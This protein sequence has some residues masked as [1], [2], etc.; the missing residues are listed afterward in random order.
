[1]GPRIYF[2]EE[3]TYNPETLFDSDST[4]DLKSSILFDLARKHHLVIVCSEPGYC[5]ASTLRSVGIRAE[6]LGFRFVFRDFGGV[7]PD[8]AYDSIIRAARDAYAKSLNTREPSVVALNLL[9]P[10]DEL[11][12]GRIAHAI[13]RLLK[14]N[15]EVI[16][17]MLP[18]ARQIIEGLPAHLLLTAADLCD[19]SA[20]ARDGSGFVA[21]GEGFTRGIPVLARS[22]LSYKGDFRASSLPQAYWDVLGKLVEA[23]MR[24]S[25]CEDELRL[26]FAIAVLG[27]GSHSELERALGLVDHDLLYDLSLWAPLYGVDVEAGSFSCL[28]AH[29]H[30]WSNGDLPAF[31]ALA[32][33]QQ[34]LLGECLSV[35]GEREDYDRM[36]AMLR[37]ASEATASRIAAEWAPELVDAGYVRQVSA[38]IASAKGMAADNPRLILIDQMVIALT[39][40][41]TGTVADV[42]QLCGRF[43]S[44]DEGASLCLAM[45]GL[46]EQLRTLSGSEV[47]L[48]GSRSGLRT[49]LEVHRG[50]LEA[51]MSGRFG[52]ALELLMPFASNGDI[53][54]VT[55]CLLRADLA[56]AQIFAC[57]ASWNDR[58]D[59]A[60]CK[61]YL[62]SRGYFGL[63]GYV[64]GLE[65]IAEA[66]CT[67]P[68][69]TSGLIRSKAAKSGDL[70]IKALA[71]VSEAFGLL[72]RKP[73][74]YILAAVS[75]ARNACK[76][77]SW[78]YGA[79]VCGVLNQVAHFQLGEC[80]GLYVVG[81]N[82]G[83]GA[84]SEVVGEL[85]HDARTGV[86]PAAAKVRPVPV[87][88]LW[89]IIALCD[90]MGEVSYALEDQ[91][92]V[93]WRRA[94]DVARK[95]SLN[96]TKLLGGIGGSG[97]AARARDMVSRGV[98]ITVF[99]GFSLIADG[100]KVS[101][102]YLGVRDAKP[103]LEFL[104]LQPGHVASREHIALMLWPEVS[105]K[106]KARQKVYSA[107][108]AARKALLKHGFKGDVFSSNKATKSVGLTSDV[109]SCDVDD[110]ICHAN[111]AIDG[112]GDVRICDSALKAEGLYAGDLCILSDD[113]SGYLAMR[114]EEL[115]RLY[116]DSM[117]AGG[118]AALRLDKKRLAA[119]FANDALYIDELREDA[120]A[121]LIRA[122]RRSGR[123]DEALRRYK[124]FAVKLAEAT[125]RMPSAA[126]QAAM[127]EPIGVIMRE[128]EP[129]PALGEACE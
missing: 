42:G 129:A 90:G 17:S 50:A 98:R 56:A 128:A 13:E 44:A 49:R 64:W 26:R 84:V 9:P 30:Q 122:L 87:D 38:A 125:G 51:M 108:A 63:L 72:H 82:D 106:A 47:I 19:V 117:V 83:V 60:A 123:G 41:R 58:G 20:I 113:Q 120:M 112:A 95:N 28:T 118:E 57:G 81:E 25:L 101:D 54:S 45:I 94:L 119:R 121:L 96:V 11:E 77:L 59:L 86:V 16:V 116:A 21:S 73:S 124:R 7:G 31:A 27:R 105:D 39:S 85:A 1:M 65:L 6:R 100:K 93:E 22:L 24:D 76:E 69:G 75:A 55:G 99:G 115:R 97:S 74:A 103:L 12:A 4:D 89:L 36:A 33:R 102:W 67:S 48:G 3:K 66:L 14:S 110:F 68:A 71:L 40:E 8:S 35:L 52:R 127:T 114:R 61:E 62:T 15:C 80:A 109:V 18:E 32:A 78:T 53:S 2:H 10:C 43:P 5:S 23:G 29:S 46:R 92:P 126:L 79:R 104:A 70:L 111:A 34:P 91:I 37:F 107:T 88:E